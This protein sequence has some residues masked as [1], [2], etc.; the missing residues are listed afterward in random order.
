MNGIDTNVLVYAFDFSDPTKQLKAQRLID[1][2]VADS[3]AKLLWQVVGEFLNCLR[4]WEMQGRISGQ[5]VESHLDDLLTAFA[6]VMP[7]IATVRHSLELSRRHSLSHWDS[8]LLGA[9]IEAGI[10]TLYSEDLS[11]GVVYDS[12]KV[13]NPFV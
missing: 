5:D 4:R 11:H 7:T 9:C 3:S 13:M 2:L 12:V 6:V 1:D 10:D 8:M